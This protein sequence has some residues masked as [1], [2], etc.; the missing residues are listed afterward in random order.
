M[1]AAALT[2]LTLAILVTGPEFHG[3]VLRRVVGHTFLLAGSI[4]VALT[5]PLALTAS[6]RARR[7]LGPH[8]KTLHRLAYVLLDH[9]PDS[10]GL[11]VRLPTLFIAALE[12]SVPL[13]VMRL[14][15]VREWWSAAR[16]NHR[17]LALR[18]ASAGG[19]WTLFGMGYVT[20]F[21]E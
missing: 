8:W 1:A 5:I 21:H 18:W 9:D 16:R 19:L 13:L 15:F 2:D 4:S 11:L 10:P 12:M 7:W 3:G 6:R 20:I 14:S 17:H